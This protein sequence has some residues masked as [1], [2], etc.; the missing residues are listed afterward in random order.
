MSKKKIRR[1]NGR[2]LSVDELAQKKIER[3][4]AGML[5]TPKECFVCGKPFERTRETTGSWKVAVYEDQGAIRLYCPECWN[6]ARDVVDAYK[7]YSRE[8]GDS[9]N[10]LSPEDALEAMSRTEMSEE[11]KEQE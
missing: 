9:R 4:A 5:N 2:N 1:I 11:E 6:M 10:I 7:E 3:Q 8:A